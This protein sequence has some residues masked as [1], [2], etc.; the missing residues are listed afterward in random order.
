M[1]GK[2]EI[3]WF[4]VI[5]KILFLVAFAL[6]LFWF[7]PSNTSSNSSS[8]DTSK[9]DFSVLFDRIFKENLNEFFFAIC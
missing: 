3:N 6:I 9:W 1:K 2:W 5:T 7:Y 8:S 4:D